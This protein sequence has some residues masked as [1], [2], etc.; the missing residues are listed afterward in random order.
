MTAMQEL[1][2]RV[3]VLLFQN[4]AIKRTNDYAYQMARRGVKVQ[5]VVADGQGWRRAP[6]LHP[7]VEVY[8][9]A[10][11][12][13][14]QP[15]LWLYETIVERV[16]SGVLRRL[17]GKVP[18]AGRAR[19]LHRRAAGFC[20]R[21][22]FWKVY[23]PLRHQA[24]RQIAW[25]RVQRLDLGAADVVICPDPATI[26]LGWSLAKRHSG[27]EVTRAL[28]YGP[29]KDHPVV[30]DLRPWDPEDPDAATRDAYVPL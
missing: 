30:E 22:V 13:N 16:P 2:E 20:R 11:P 1:P 14:R 12:E 7:C 21:N 8:S 25:R 24:L 19:R 9:L 17:D 10:K 26:P 3:V 4:G 28:H 5:A 29:Y 23:R 6:S 15:L 18:G 27:P